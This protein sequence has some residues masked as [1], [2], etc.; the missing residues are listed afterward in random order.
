MSLLSLEQF[1]CNGESTSMGARWERWKRA[2]LIYLE[3]SNIDKDVKKRASLLHFGGI[4]LQEVFYNIP[5]ANVEPTEGEDVFEV[6]ISKLDAYF[7]PKQSKVYERHIFRLLKQEPDEKCEKFVLRLR[8][9][10]DKCQFANRY[11]NIIDQITEKCFL[12]ELRK[13]ILRIGDEITLEQVIT[14]ANTL[15]VVNK[16][17]EEFKTPLKSIE[18]QEVNRIDSKFKR[19]FDTSRNVEYGCGRCGNLRHAGN[20]TNCPARDKE[21][22]KCGLK[23]H[24][25]QYCRTK[26]TLKRKGEREYRYEHKKGRFNRKKNEVNQVGESSNNIVHKD[27]ET[28]YVFHI[29]DDV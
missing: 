12:P 27:G 19:N 25:R 22:L 11:E 6:A 16:Q 1:D 20:D 21:C 24:F 15:E 3:A 23:G 5:G 29:D 10:A 17:L 4:D 28:E 13:K 14:E 18:N 26:Q 8:K 2:L 7:A 9:Q